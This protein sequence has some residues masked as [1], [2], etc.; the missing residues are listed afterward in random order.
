MFFGDDAGYILWSRHATAAHNKGHQGMLAPNAPD[1]VKG[2]VVLP[3]DGKVT[4]GNVAQNDVGMSFLRSPPQRSID[5]QHADDAIAFGD[6]DMAQPAA[7]VGLGQKN[8]K[9]H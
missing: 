5:P 4:A 7:V 3:H 1:H 9:I 6:G 8:V 2:D